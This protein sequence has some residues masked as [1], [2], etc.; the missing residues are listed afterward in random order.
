[1]YREVEGIG[2]IKPRK[3]FNLDA[4]RVPERKKPV[5]SASNTALENYKIALDEL[6][7]LGVKNI[8]WEL[9]RLTDEP[10]AWD[11][12]LNDG[13]G[14]FGMGNIRLELADAVKT[15]LIAS[16]GI[17]TPFASPCLGTRYIHFDS[18][19]SNA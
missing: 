5:L 18:I 9:S 1:M 15:E 13:H 11:F 14:R 3:V 8:K 19:A 16:V 12:Q 17:G 2:R 10:E 6:T 4:P 7:N